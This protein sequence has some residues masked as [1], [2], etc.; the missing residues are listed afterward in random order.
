[1]PGRRATVPGEVFG[2][3]P[4]ALEK[5]TGGAEV[6]RETVPPANGSTVPPDH[7]F[8]AAAANE[9]AAPA[10]GR[11]AGKTGGEKTTF[12]LRPDQL[13]KLDELALAYRRR[14]GR[15]IDRQDIVR[16]LIDYC[17]LDTLGEV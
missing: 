15:R 7:R 17:T 9:S 16:A 5:L 1:M 13:D 4:T 10:P 8:T 2:R 14:T 11:K 12:Y 6:D 3:R